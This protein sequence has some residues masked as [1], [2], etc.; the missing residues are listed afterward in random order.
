MA[1]VLIAVCGN[2]ANL[3]WRRSARQR[4]FGIGWRWRVE[5]RAARLVLIKPPRAGRHGRRAAACRVGSHV[6][7]RPLSIPLPVRLRR[8]STA[9]R[10]R[11]PWPRIVATLHGERA[12]VFLGRLQPFDLVRDG[13][14]AAAVARCVRH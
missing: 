2:V 12:H 7:G 9:A 1:L 14:G 5:F 8:R 10:S 13:I 3:P 11:S 4:E 6:L